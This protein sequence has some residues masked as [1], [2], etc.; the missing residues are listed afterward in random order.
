MEEIRM[1][2]LSVEELDQ[3]SGGR[4]GGYDQKPRAKHGCKIH[5]VVHGETLTKIAS[6][7]GTT[8]QKIMAVNPE[9]TDPTFIQPGC[10]MYVPVM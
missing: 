2:E 3:V 9:L 5:K 1:K 10:Y 4:S 7:Y 6:H 8:V